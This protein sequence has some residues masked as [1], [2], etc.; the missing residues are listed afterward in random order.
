MCDFLSTT[1][2]RLVIQNHYLGI[3]KD[4]VLEWSAAALFVDGDLIYQTLRRVDKLAHPPQTCKEGGCAG[5]S[6]LRFV[7]P[8]VS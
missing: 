8:F 6:T 2:R 4:R 7:A 5:L 3:V 1:G